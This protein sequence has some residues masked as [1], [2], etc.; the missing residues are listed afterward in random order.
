MTRAERISAGPV[1]L[2]SRYHRRDQVHGT[3]H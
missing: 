2:G 3:H 1:G